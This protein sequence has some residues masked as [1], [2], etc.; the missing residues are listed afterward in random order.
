MNI[1]ST[2]HYNVRDPSHN[3]NDLGFDWTNNEYKTTLTS[4][5]LK[6][7]G[8]TIYRFCKTE[9]YTTDRS[10]RGLYDAV[11]YIE[12]GASSLR[13]PQSIAEVAVRSAGWHEQP[14]LE[15][16][17]ILYYCGFYACNANNNGDTSKCYPDFDADDD[18]SLTKDLSYASLKKTSDKINDC[19]K[20]GYLDSDDI[21]ASDKVAAYNN[22]LNLRSYICLAENEIVDFLT[23]VYKNWA[24]EDDA[25]SLVYGRH[26]ADEKSHGDWVVTSNGGNPH[27][28]CA[29]YS[30]VYEALTDALDELSTTCKANQ[31]KTKSPHTYGSKKRVSPGYAKKS[32]PNYD[33]SDDRNS[34]DYEDSFLN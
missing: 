4:A 13:R 9:Q 17:G 29:K 19:I 23:T 25:I 7:L 8:N 16:F 14:I 22:V 24:T 27:K 1:P 18:W 11:H 20:D 28:G 33:D 32:R 26:L 5:A 6:A 15:G 12:R 34:D 30:E 2:I 10:Y 21:T 3:P 31:K